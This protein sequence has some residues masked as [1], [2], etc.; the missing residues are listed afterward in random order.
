MPKTNNR[1]PTQAQHEKDLGTEWGVDG[2]QGPRKTR[3]GAPT[4]FLRHVCPAT[5]PIAHRETCPFM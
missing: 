3:S 4:Q 2:K 5:H 1:R